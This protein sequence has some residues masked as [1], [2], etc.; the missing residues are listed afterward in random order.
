M[1]VDDLLPGLEAPLW[2]GEDEEFA[3]WVRDVFGVPDGITRIT[4]SPR[5]P[6]GRSGVLIGASKVGA[7]L[8]VIAPNA[9]TQK[10]RITP[11]VLGPLTLDADVVTRA[12]TAGAAVTEN[13]YA[14]SRLASRHLPM[15]VVRDLL[16]PYYH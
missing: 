12:H 9:S 13:A 3:D 1:S 7:I 2:E 15:D 14:L 8:F 16:T 6:S 10:T 4:I 5:G 11:V